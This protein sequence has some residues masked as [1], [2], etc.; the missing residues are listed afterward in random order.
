MFERFRKEKK[1]EEPPIRILPFD[2]RYALQY[3]QALFNEEEI[4]IL[5]EVAVIMRNQNPMWGI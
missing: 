3:K 1:K 4:E 5:K 2:I